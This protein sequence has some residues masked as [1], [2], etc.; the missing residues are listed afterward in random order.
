MDAH[1]RKPHNTESAVAASSSDVSAD[2]EMIHSIEAR[3]AAQ[4]GDVETLRALLGAGQA[5]PDSV[6][7]DD[8]SLLH[9]AAIN[10]RLEVVH[11]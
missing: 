8:C 7:S 1:P 2:M 3:Q 5:T 10:N 9:W 6:D 11:A 4:Y